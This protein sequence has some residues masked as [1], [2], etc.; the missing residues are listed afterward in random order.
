MLADGVEAVIRVLED[1]TD[2]RVRDAISH[3]VKQRIDEGQLDDAPLTLGQI[4]RVKEAFRRSLS[5]MYH[6]RI[7]YPAESGGITAHWSA[8][9]G[10]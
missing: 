9:A 2:K 8:A 6:N 7:E 5:G 3:V 4:E 10:A 1:P